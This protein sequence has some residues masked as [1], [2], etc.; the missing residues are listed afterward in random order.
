MPLYRRLP[1][2]GFY[3]PFR[4]EYAVVNLD[5][6]ARFPSGSIVDVDRLV[7]AR[8]IK[9]SDRA[10]VKILGHGTLQQPLTVKAH[11]FS[12]RARAKIEELGGHVEVVSA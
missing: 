8:L 2:R 11:A 1:K 12:S 7:E 10:A 5:D 9:K 6:L 3:N 4:R